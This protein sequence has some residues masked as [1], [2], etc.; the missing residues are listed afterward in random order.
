[1]AVDDTATWYINRDDKCTKVVVDWVSDS[2]AGTVSQESDWPVFG[3]LMRV[4]TVPSATAAPDANYDFTIDDEQ[5]VDIAFATLAN[6]HTSNTETVYPSVTSSGTNTDFPSAVAG[7]ITITGA[8][9]GN[10]K[11][12]KIVMY[13]V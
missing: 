5:S 10:S 13:F 2:A 8:A 1:M 7:R 9:C 3:Q 11:E 4:T 12:G 6:R